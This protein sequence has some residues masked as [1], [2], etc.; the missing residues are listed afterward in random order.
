[1]RAE[2]NGDEPVGAADLKLRWDTPNESL[3][4]FDERLLVTF[5][6][7]DPAADMVDQDRK[8]MLS[9]P[10]IAQ[11][12]KL[13]DEFPNFRVTVHYGVSGNDV[14]LSDCKVNNFSLEMLA[15]GTVKIGMRIQCHPSEQD[16]GRLYG[17]QKREIS[18]TIQKE[19]SVQA[20]IEDKSDS[21][22]F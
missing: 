6:T 7:V 22:P 18:V 13:K 14:V 8:T 2:A 19:P 3:G 1:V 21:E 10:G 16:V 4:M 17:M 11:P 9:F 20:S 12:I 15:G 5:Y